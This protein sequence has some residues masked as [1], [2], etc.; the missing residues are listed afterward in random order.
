[1]PNILFAYVGPETVV[2]VASALAA[3]G[4][5]LLM[6]WTHVKAFVGGCIRF[7]LR[8]KARS[9]ETETTGR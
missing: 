2:P 1:M 8:R 7:V 6:C 5:V 3:I 4:G 9:V